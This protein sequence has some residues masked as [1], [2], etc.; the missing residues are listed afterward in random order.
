[1]KF[2]EFINKYNGKHVDYDGA[3][4]AQ[5]VDLFRMFAKEVLEIGQAKAVNGAKDFWRN[6]ESDPNLYNNFI[7]IK[8]TLSFVPQKGDI[9]I[10]YNGTYGHIAICTGNGD[11]RS[12]EI[13]EQNR[14]V[15]H[16]CRIAKDYYSK[17]YGV[18]R[19][20]NQNNLIDYY[21]VRVDKKVAMVRSQP[22]SNSALAGSQK[23]VKG[24]IFNV[25]GT[26]IG[27]S[28]NGNNIWYKSKV[29]NFVW[30]GGLRRI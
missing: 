27:E 26:V 25:V 12:F 16:R 3:Y 18:F 4:G 2:N 19:P 17:F 9:A 11:T 1:M 24:D 22:N 28:V 14:P 29:G 20:K 15:G 6:Y 8:N 10:W 21:K 13:F 23:L 5:C 7:R 30:S